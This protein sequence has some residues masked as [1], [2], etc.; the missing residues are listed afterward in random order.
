MLRDVHS[1]MLMNPMLSDIVE[2]LNEYSRFFWKE[3]LILDR[4]NLHAILTQMKLD[5]FSQQRMT[6]A[7]NVN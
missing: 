1:T 4:D 7:V 2:L 6:Y 3:M 5:M